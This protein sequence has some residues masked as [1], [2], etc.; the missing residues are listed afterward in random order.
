MAYAKK[1]GTIVAVAPFAAGRYFAPPRGTKAEQAE[2]D[3]RERAIALDPNSVVAHHWYA[4]FLIAVG[5][6]QDALAEIEKA[7]KLDPK[8]SAILADKGLILFLAGQKIGRFGLLK[9][10]ETTEPAFLSPHAYLAEAD[11]DAKNYKDYLSESRKAALIL[12][13]QS[14]LEI[15]AAG[16]KGFAVSGGAGMLRALL[17]ARKSSMPTEGLTRMTWTCPIAY[18]GTSSTR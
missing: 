7:R 3:E 18:W 5:R 9:Q 8:S 11:L 13:D 17:S 2:A 1:R 14:R 16:E 4:T 12:Q 10:I 15:V 6:S